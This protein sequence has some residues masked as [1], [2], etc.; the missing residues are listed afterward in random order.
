MLEAEKQPP[1]SL[2]KLRHWLHCDLKLEVRFYAS[3]LTDLFLA[4]KKPVPKQQTK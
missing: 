3:V 2:K 1:R 4:Y